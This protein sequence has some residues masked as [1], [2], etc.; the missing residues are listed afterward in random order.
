MATALQ[1][2]AAE[3]TEA[4]A[5]E[6]FCIISAESWATGKVSRGG[7]VQCP[8]Y[9]EPRVLNPGSTSCPCVR[10]LGR[11]PPWHYSQ[12]NRLEDN[13]AGMKKTA[14]LVVRNEK[15]TALKRRYGGEI[16]EM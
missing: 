9:G 4:R 5:G 13:S 14:I 3:H 8:D 11:V 15:R 1:A 2:E 12:E 10:Q 6:P 7:E 16:S